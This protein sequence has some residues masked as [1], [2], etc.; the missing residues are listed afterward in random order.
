MNK[1]SNSEKYAYIYSKVFEIYRKLVKAKKI[2]YWNS[3][4]NA[5]II[6]LL[7]DYIFHIEK[8]INQNNK[9][10]KFNSIIQNIEKDFNLDNTKIGLVKN[11]FHLIINT[12][13]KFFMK[14]EYIQIGSRERNID[15]FLKNKSSVAL[16]LNAKNFLIKKNIKI[17]NKKKYTLEID[18]FLFQIAKKFNLKDDRYKNKLFIKLRKNYLYFSSLKDL[19]LP[20]IGQKK[21]IFNVPRNIWNRCFAI[22]YKIN[23]KKKIYAFDHGPIGA[24]AINQ[25]LS[26]YHEIHV[27]DYFFTNSEVLKKTYQKNKY[28]KK[29]LSLKKIVNLNFIKSYDNLK[30]KNNHSNNKKFLLVGYPH[31]YPGSWYPNFNYKDGSEEVLKLEKKIISILKSNNY[32]F[33]YQIHPERV[34]ETLFFLRSEKL[35]FNFSKFEKIYNQ[36]THIIYPSVTTSTF[37]IGLISKKKIIGLIHE[38][39]EFFLDK[40]YQNNSFMIK[41]KYK[42]K[43]LSFDKNKFLKVLK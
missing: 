14:P 29:I 9:T 15:F 37:D 23:H 38:D 6:K 22:N 27:C 24:F 35:T 26:P 28:L 40:N 17:L 19:D 3:I 16:F 32:E 18:T 25:I 31:R 5:N 42:K 20:K 7:T 13:K 39:D 4:I 11:F 36:F 43:E 2:N 34:E 10:K 41:W 33:T 21:I 30:I 1:V 12:Y 8:N